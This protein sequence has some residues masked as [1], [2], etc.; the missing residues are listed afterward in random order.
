INGIREEREA[1]AVALRQ[2]AADDML[3]K[4]KEELANYEAHNGGKAQ[5]LQQQ[6]A[7]EEEAMNKRMAILDAE[8]KANK[9]SHT[10]YDTQLLQLKEATAQKIT[11]LTVEHANAEIALYE[12]THKSKIDADTLLT[13]DIVD[14]ETQRLNTIR[15]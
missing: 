14:E 2:K 5:S 15:Q 1:K 10:A 4:L 6:L 12:A 9:I 11:A 13:Q 8:L 3:T 7:Y